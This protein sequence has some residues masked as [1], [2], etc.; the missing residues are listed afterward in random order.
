MRRYKLS[1]AQIIALGFLALISAGSLLL[2]LPE[3]AASGEAPP[4]LTALFTAVS[5]SCV[6]GLTVVDTGTFWSPLGQAVILLMIQIGGLGFMTMATMFVRLM[7]RRVSMRERAVMAESINTVQIGRVLGITRLI[8]TGSMLL[9]LIGAALLSIRFIPQLGPGRGIWYA[10][11]HSVSALCN[12]GFDL[13]GAVYEPFCSFTHYSDDPLVVLTLSFLIVAGGI[14]FLVWDDVLRRGLRP[15][16]W[17]MHTKLTVC[18]TAALIFGGAALFFVFEAGRMNRAMPLGSQALASLFFAVTPRTAGFNTVDTA[19]L[20][21]ASRLLTVILMFIG[22]SSGSTAGGV[23]T[24][25]AAVALLCAVSAM[26]GRRETCV[27][28]RRV[29]E[30]ALRRAAVVMT[31]NLALALAGALAILGAQALSAEDV[32]FE[33][34]SAIGTVG[35]STGVTRSLSGPSLG[36]IAFLMFCGRIGSMSF[37][38]ALLEKKAAPPVRYP[39]EQL[40]VG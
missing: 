17:E 10:L 22:G 25:T 5:A 6:T 1:H 31:V 19:A 26:R 18:S 28:R 8:F 30:D 36:V 3:S 33:C 15:R 37:A 4:F 29:P 27:F 16:R 40:T 2:M 38:L 11:F 34:F 12:A 7:R 21:P 9:E 14:G 24:T 13:M 32:L 39:E 23:K 20:S 35:M